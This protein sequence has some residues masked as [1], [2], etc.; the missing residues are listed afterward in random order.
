MEKI[1]GLDLFSGYGGGELSLEDWVTPIAYC[2]NEQYAQAQLLSRMSEGKLPVAPIWDDITTLDGEE[3]LLLVGRPIEIIKAGFPCQ[4]IS[5]AGNGAG[6]GGKRSGL[7]FEVMRLAEEIK[8][9]FIFLENV[10]AIRTRGLR[11]VGEELARIGYDCRWGVVSARE[12]GANHLRKRWFCLA[13]ASSERRQQEPHGSHGHE[14]KNGSKINNFVKRHGKSNS[15]RRVSGAVANTDLSRLI[16]ESYATSKENNEREWEGYWRSKASTTSSNWWGTEPNVGRVVNGCAFELDFIKRGRAFLDKRKKKEE[17]GVLDE[18][19]LNKKSKS[20]TDEFIREVLS[21]LWKFREI[22]K[23]S[24]GVYSREICDSLPEMPYQCPQKRRNM[25]AWLKE[26]EKLYS[27]FESVFS[28]EGESENMWEALL[29]RLREK[30]CNEEMEYSF[31][32]DRIKQ[33]GNGV[34]PLQEKTA[35]KRLL[36]IESR[37]KPEAPRVQE[38]TLEDIL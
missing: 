36:G 22:A 35:F 6:L 15:E 13:Y 7:F 11:E 4:D 21:R 30:E 28:I 5:V 19:K 27:L 3:L 25:G 24:P 23:A 31:R 38:L 18:E 2:E 10:P 12:V 37:G 1:Y 14:R 17:K 9:S 16:R 33:L 8:P 26:D 34:V 20:K 32:V 29:E